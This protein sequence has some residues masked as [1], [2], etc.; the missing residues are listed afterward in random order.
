[1]ATRTRIEVAPK[2][3]LSP[4]AR[5][6]VTAADHLV[7]PTAKLIGDTL[8]Q[9]AKVVE[10]STTE[11]AKQVGREGNGSVA[12]LVG[13]TVEQSLKVPEVAVRRTW[14]WIDTFVAEAARVTKSVRKTVET[15]AS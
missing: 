7:T 3:E 15:A 5:E 8:T 2:P 12:R 10:V 13:D 9:A 1:M 6:V 11:V 14:E 4:L